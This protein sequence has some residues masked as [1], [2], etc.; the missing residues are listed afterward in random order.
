M[1]FGQKTEEAQRLLREGI[2]GNEIEA[3]AGV[4]LE[5]LGIAAAAGKRVGAGTARRAVEREVPLGDSRRA[6][7]FEYAPLMGRLGL[8]I[9]GVRAVPEHVSAAIGGPA[10][11]LRLPLNCL[12]IA[13]SVV[14]LL[15]DG[16]PEVQAVDVALFGDGAPP[17]A[18]LFSAAAERSRARVVDP[19]ALAPAQLARVFDVRAVPQTD[20]AL[21]PVEPHCPW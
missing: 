8:R 12:L 20:G 2:A 5:A 10:V 9:A 3:A 19:A 4:L 7:L 21:G 18:C 13:R 11:N 15:L 14:Y 6:F 17:P 1:L 16:L